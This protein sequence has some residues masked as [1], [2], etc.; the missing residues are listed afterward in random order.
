MDDDLGICSHRK[1]ALYGCVSV[2][3]SLN[4]C[5]SKLAWYG[6]MTEQACVFWSRSSGN[7]CLRK[8]VLTDFNN[9]YFTRLSDCLYKEG[10]GCAW[11]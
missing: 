1:P 8:G 3:M 7:W 4:N 5:R 10:D 6:N 9:L 11:C 2:G